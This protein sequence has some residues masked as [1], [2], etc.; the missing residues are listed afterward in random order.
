MGSYLSSVTI[1]L[2]FEKLESAK[3]RRR[4]SESFTGGKVGLL[5]VHFQSAKTIAPVLNHFLLPR[6]G[7]DDEMW[8]VTGSGS[9]VQSGHQK[10]ESGGVL[11]NAVQRWLEEQEEKRVLEFRIGKDT[12]GGKNKISGGAFLVRK[13]T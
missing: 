5:D 12:S 11:F 7:K 1:P 10:R 3:Q 2:S 4:R 6:I 8:I 13:K 9:H